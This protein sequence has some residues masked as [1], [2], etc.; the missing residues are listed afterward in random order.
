MQKDGFFLAFISYQKII[1]ICI[2]IIH[3]LKENDVFL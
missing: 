3:I 1:L 2:I